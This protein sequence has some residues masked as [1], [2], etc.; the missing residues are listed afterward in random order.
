MAFPATPLAVT[1]EIAL[2][3]DLTASPATWA[4]TDIS[5]YLLEEAGV[6]ISRGRP[7]EFATAPPARCRLYLNN[8]DGRFTR[9]NPLGAYYGQLGKQTPLRIR[10]DPGSGAVTRFVGYIDELPPRWDPSLSHMWVP[11]TASGV[12]RRLQQGRTLR[13]ALYRAHTIGGVFGFGTSAVAYWPMEDEANAVTFASATGGPPMSIYSITP[14]A[15][16]D[17][18][19]TAPLPV[20]G[21][22]GHF[23]GVVPTYTT[24]TSWAVRWAM[25][26]HE[27][28][29]T[30]TG[31]V[32]WT[33]PAGSIVRWIIYLTPGSPDLI[34]LEGHNS[35]GTDVISDAG[36][37]FEIDSDSPYGRQ[38]YFEVNAEQDGADIDWSYTFH[39]GP[40]KVGT[41]TSA[42]IGNVT[43]VYGS[44][45]PGYADGGYT[46]GHIA[47][48]DDVDF[49]AGLFGP[50]A[51]TDEETWARHFRLCQEEGIPA[52]V[53]TN[54]E[55]TASDMGPQGIGTIVELLREGETA[56]V[57]VLYDGR[58]GDLTLQTRA[59]R[60][61]RDVDLAL[62]FDAGEVALDFLPTDDDLRTRNDWEVST[63]GGTRGRYVDADHV[64]ANFGA[65]YDDAASVNLSPS[66]DP[67]H[68]ASW[69]VHVGTVDDIRTPQI[70]IDLHRS[71]GLITDWLT[72]DIGSRV[73]V[74]NPPSGMPPDDL[75]VLIEGYTETLRPFAW[76]VDINGAPAAPYSVATVDDGLQLDT[77]SEL[78]VGYDSSATSLLIAH[79]SLPLGLVAPPLWSTTAEPYDWHIAGE[80]VT[81]T[82][83]ATNLITFVN[84]G[85]AA[86]ANNASVTPSLPASITKGDLLL[87]FAAI[88]NSGTGTVD[89]PT[90]YETLL[91]FGNMALFGKIH[92]GSEA[93]PTVSFSNGAANADTSAQMA[94]FRS[95]QNAVQV[96]ATVLNSSAANITYP[97]LTGVDRNN[98]LILYLGWKQ[99][100]W[101]SVA[102]PGTEIGEPDTTTGDDQGIVWAYQ[103]QT[104]VTEI[105]TGTFTVTGGGSAI[106]R[107]AVVAIKGD[108][109]TATV[110]R[111]VNTVAKSQVAGA[112]VS[113]WRAT[114]IAL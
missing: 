89:E 24:A 50:D 20:F 34:T 43:T 42:T 73:T 103:I 110:T 2:S 82:A 30:K 81:A 101:T 6:T 75:D 65:V 16:T 5:A 38:I 109:Q 25:K 31:L 111:S 69:R 112:A 26:L 51:Y 86:H 74:A 106:S 84:A 28:P 105:A 13:S 57:G 77:S 12:L 58:T 70:S 53:D 27:A 95:A 98:M 91:S 19:G 56:D 87:V 17:M 40:G 114:A 8:A 113:L 68:H 62:D 36:S 48:S 83:L 54:A 64:S 63:T 35:A 66:E 102:G 92:D 55:V 22:F 9:T 88:R 1:A 32:A 59:Y 97:A 78:L 15:E 14:A 37:I 11:V 72:C 47:V 18:V 44:A 93:A 39:P 71:T 67:Y 45:Y 80:Q 90:D 79:P 41:E 76:R 29:T 60:Y 107:G 46:L 108:V 61:N 10:V 85:T 94:A 7:D 21:P 104:T 33:T 3:A 4:W 99:D 23:F 52:A 96:S 49:G 100:D